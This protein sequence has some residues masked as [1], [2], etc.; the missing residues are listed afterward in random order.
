MCRDNT[1]ALC[2]RG[3]HRGLE[4]AILQLARTS[5]SHIQSGDARQRRR[6]TK[7]KPQPTQISALCLSSVQCMLR[8]LPPDLVQLVK[9][10]ARYPRLSLHMGKTLNGGVNTYLPGIGAVGPDHEPEKDFVIH[11]CPKTTSLSPTCTHEDGRQFKCADCNRHGPGD[12]C[13]NCPAITASKWNRIGWH[14]GPW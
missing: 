8:L 7:L 4:D 5:P 6:Q 1:A 14:Q 11:L 12:A 2:H 13:V 9:N 3:E 10:H